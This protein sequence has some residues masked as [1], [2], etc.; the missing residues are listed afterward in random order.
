MYLRSCEIY[1][2]E[3]A[4]AD[5][6]VGSIRDETRFNKKLHSVEMYWRSREIYEMSP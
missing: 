3:T 6:Q 5:P 2:N 1:A 4:V